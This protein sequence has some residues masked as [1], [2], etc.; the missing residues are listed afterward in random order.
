MKI[1]TSLNTATKALLEVCSRRG[2]RADD[3]LAK[4]EIDPA[5]FERYNVRIPA[6]KKR[7]IWEE[8][9]RR[10]GDEHLGLRAA[11]IVPF[12][13][14][15]VLDYLLFA[16]PTLGEVLNRTSRFY[17]LINSNAEL[18]LRRHKRFVLVELYN[19]NITSQQRLGLS[20]EYSFAMLLLRVRLAYGKEFKPEKVCFTHSAPPNTALHRKLFR[21]PM[22]FGQAV[23]SLVFSE[24]LPVAKTGQSDPELAEMLEHHAQRLLRGLPAEDDIAQEVREVL[25]LRLSNG[26]VSLDAT[27]KTLAMSGR[28]LQRKLNSQGTSYRKVLDNLR[29]E[30]AFYYTAQRVEVSETARLLGFTETSALYRA[31]KRWALMNS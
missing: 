26:D 8:A 6:D 28:S 25:R 11:E 31:L 22:H 18:R 7:L 3:L 17:R 2:V 15:G 27:A 10:V 21:S 1:G 29:H 24:D 12:G 23:N 14:Y 4:A 30:L 19:S 9:Q 13:G 20:A 5:L 16:T